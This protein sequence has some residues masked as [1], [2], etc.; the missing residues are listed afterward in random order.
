MRRD[1]SHKLY[2]R[3]IFLALEVPCQVYV[4]WRLCNSSIKTYSICETALVQFSWYGQGPP[5]ELSLVLKLDFVYAP[6][7]KAV[8]RT[9]A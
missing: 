5:P 7:H 6:G 9:C 3:A 1:G 4:R 2:K 8:P